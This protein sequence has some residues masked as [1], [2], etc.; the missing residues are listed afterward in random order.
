MTVKLSK[1]EAEQQ[2]S[3]MTAKMNFAVEWT[4]SATE[5]EEDSMG[6][7]GDLPICRKKLQQ[8]RLHEQSQPGQQLDEVIEQI[9][10]LMLKS[11]QETASNEKLSRR[12]TTTTARK[13]VA[14]AT[15]RWSRETTPKSCLGSR[16]ISTT[17]V[18]SS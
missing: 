14:T 15:E 3:D 12:E 18:E 1:G 11:A 5:D 16:R 13:E 17:R 4:L 6:D 2:L 7:H 10:R 9:R 8:R